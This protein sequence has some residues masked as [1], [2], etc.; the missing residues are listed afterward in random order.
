MILNQSL[1]LLDIL[2]Q[3]ELD[4]AQ[5]DLVSNVELLHDLKLDGTLGK[6]VLLVDTNAYV[7]YRLGETVVYSMVDD[8]AFGGAAA[9]FGVYGMHEMPFDVRGPRDQWDVIEVVYSEV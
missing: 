7:L 6:V 5:R 4:D 2:A 1:A 3:V 8:G 9:V